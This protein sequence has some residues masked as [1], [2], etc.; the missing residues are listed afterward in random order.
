MLRLGLTVL[1]VLS[2]ACFGAGLASAFVVQ[3]I[4]PLGIFPSEARRV[5]SRGVSLRYRA[6][7]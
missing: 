7:C 6:T 2:L 5:T 4:T 1:C 3:Q